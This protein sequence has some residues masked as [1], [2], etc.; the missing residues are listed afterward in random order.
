MI[1]MMI[2]IILAMIMIIIAHMHEINVYLDV[3]QNHKAYRGAVES[4]CA[5]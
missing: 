1:M 4:L 3:S 2:V 5:A